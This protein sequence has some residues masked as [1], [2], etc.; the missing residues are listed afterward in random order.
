MKYRQ[1]QESDDASSENNNSSRA[2]DA[3]RDD[4][5][6]WCLIDSKLDDICT[7]DS[8]NELLDYLREVQQDGGLVFQASMR[9]VSD[10]KATNSE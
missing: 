5:L 1:Y 7:F 4:G 3:A 2:S 10:S 6:P 8:D 9:N